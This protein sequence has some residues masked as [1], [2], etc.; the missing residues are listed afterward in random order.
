M[1]TPPVPCTALDVLAALPTPH[2]S[3]APTCTSS[4][5]RSSAASV[6]TAALKSVEALLHFRKLGRQLSHMPPSALAA[7]TATSARGHG[8][9]RGALGRM[10]ARKEPRCRGNA[11]EGPRSAAGAALTPVPRRL[12]CPLSRVAEAPSSAQHGDPRQRSGERADVARFPR[13]LGGRRGGA[14]RRSADGGVRGRN[15]SVGRS[16]G[17]ADGPSP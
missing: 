15:Q 1:P 12:R 9:G 13:R 7:V 3:S 10:V 5:L 4:S 2:A 6:V 16:S 11:E 14:R 17:L 8:D